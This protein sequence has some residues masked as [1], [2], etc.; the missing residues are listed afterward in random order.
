MVP[1]TDAAM[2]PADRLRDKIVAINGKGFQSYQELAG[3][4]RFD[5]FV[6]YLD[7]IQS[8]PVAAPTRARVRI[9]QAEAQVPPG[10]WATPAQHV[11]V[12]DFLTRRLQEAIRKHVRSRWSGRL[13]PLA[14]DAGGQ[15]ILARTACALSEDAIEVRLAIG[16]PSEGRKVLARAAQTLLFEELPS[17]IAS[18]L[19][20][21]NLDGEAGRRHVALM[22]DY[23]AL[24]DALAPLGLVAFLADGS[25]LP[26]EPGFGDGSLRARAVPLRAPDELAVT[27]SLPHR[28]AVRGLGIRAGVTVVSGGAFS[29]KS[30][31]LAAIGAGVYPHVPGDGRE[32]VA[33][34]PDAVAIHGE[35]GRRI[36]RVDVSAFFRE[37]PQR[38][39]V[40]AFAVEHAT[41]VEA[42]AAATAEA[43]EMRTGLMLYDEDDSAV[44]FMA[45][46]AL[47][48]Q[49]VPGSQEPL[50]PLLD[51]LRPLWKS[52]GV[53]SIV[54]TGGLGDYLAVA[55]T[56]IVMEGFQPVAATA[57]ART[58]VTGAGL[59]EYDAPAPSP[60]PRY[61]LPRG[62]AGLRGRQRVEM[63][64]RTVLGVGREAVELAGI[65][66][67]VDPSQARAA[68]AAILYAIEKGY[69]DGTMPIAD[70]IDRVF[71]DTERSGLAALA[72]DD[73]VSGEHAMPRPHE[74]AAVLNRMRSLQAR[75]RPVMVEQAVDAVRSAAAAGAPVGTATP[76]TAEEH[77]ESA[78]PSPVGPASA[79]AEPR[80]DVVPDSPPEEPAPPE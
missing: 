36:E 7:T 19:A 51:H 40:T 41:G 33:T 24:R 28:G 48:R 59:R 6:L 54:A 71:A 67:L 68:G 13:P 26:R 16:L 38:H 77:A 46:D 76:G 62:F 39:D 4:Y 23:L 65:R 34:I 55:D 69:F 47:M 73:E 80:E 17:V 37:V 78:P 2:L 29:G 14:V 56:V 12:A 64:G 63:R 60:S 45:R 44:A 21:T 22:D 32:Y 9:D 42:M 15:T 18:G 5:R 20:W 79:V 72:L 3:A 1:A 8:D 53:S 66:Q 11:A 30:T 70:A 58:I 61:P 75:S 49:L 74:V 52:R 27:V 35:P 31:L 50:T 25:I 57:R 10:L 43:L